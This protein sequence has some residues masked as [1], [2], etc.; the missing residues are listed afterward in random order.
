MAHQADCSIEIT[1][2]RLKSDYIETT[3]GNSHEG[4]QGETET[5]GEVLRRRQGDIDP[6]RAEADADPG[7]AIGKGRAQGGTQGSGSAAA[8]VPLDRLDQGAQTQDTITMI[9][10]ATLC[11]WW[12]VRNSCGSR[13][14]G[15]R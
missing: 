8:P 12:Q 7:E 6:L 2:K 9:T 13:Q 15:G 11:S 10:P 5:R 14:Y 1:L 4:N 3:K